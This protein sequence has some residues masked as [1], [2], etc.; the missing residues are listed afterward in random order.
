[1]LG[2]CLIFFLFRVFE[3]NYLTRGTTGAA[4]GPKLALRVMIKDVKRIMQITP[5]NFLRPPVRIADPFVSPVKTVPDL[6]MWDLR[7]SPDPPS[8]SDGSDSSSD[9]EDE[10]CS[11]LQAGHG[12]LNGEAR[13]GGRDSGQ[14]ST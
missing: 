5:V 10:N 1:M 13:E 3:L 2:L 8:D 11:E 14:N 9:E 6:Y 12:R 4:M 7:P